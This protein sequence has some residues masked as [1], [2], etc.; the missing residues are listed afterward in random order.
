V[1][2]AGFCG[3]MLAQAPSGGLVVSGRVC[4]GISAASREGFW[5]VGSQ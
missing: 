1:P 4:H 2:A 3:G 5:R